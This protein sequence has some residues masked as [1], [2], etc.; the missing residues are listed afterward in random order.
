MRGEGSYPRVHSRTRLLLI[1]IAACAALSAATGPASA[2]ERGRAGNAAVYESAEVLVRFAPGVDA[3]ERAKTVGERFARVERSLPGGLAVVGLA[4]GDSVQQA[5]RELEREPGVVSAAPN[6]RRKLAARTPNDPR[7]PELWGLRKTSAA[8]AWEATTGSPSVAVAVVDTGVAGDHP[9]LSPNVWRNTAETV[10]GADDDGNGYVDDV[11]GWDFVDEDADPTDETGHGTHVAGTIGARG[12]DGVGVTGVNW[13]V[14]L[15]SLRAGSDIGLADDDI[16]E[17]FDYACRKGARVV[18]GSFSGGP[19]SF[20]QPLLDSILACPSALF[21]F[22]AGNEGLD[23]DVDPSYPCNFEAPNI[24]CVAA[25]DSNDELPGWSNHGESVDLAAPGTSILSS[26]AAHVVFSDS[27]DGPSLDGWETGGTG[28]WS[29]TTEASAS[30]PNS[31]TESPGGP[32]AENAAAWLRRTVPA[33]LRGYSR[34]GLEWVMQ[35]DLDWYDGVMIQVSRDQTWD[36]LDD[37]WIWTGSTGGAFEWWREDIGDFDGRARAFVGFEFISG[38]DFEPLDGVHLDDVAV[39]CYAGP[40]APTGYES[41]DGTSMATPHVAGAAALVLASWPGA[42]VAEL[43]RRLFEDVDVVP[44]LSG[45][46]ATGGRLN[47][48]KALGV[49]VPP[50]P[51]PAEPPPPPAE[52]PPPAPPGPPPP[53]AQP[54]PPRAPVQARCIVPNVKGKTVPA[55]RIALG[56]ARCALGRVT[57]AYS[58][59]VR[60]SRIIVQSRRVGSRH[61]RGTRVSVVVSRG[62]RR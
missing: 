3:L 7:W 25:S 2:V 28:V 17:A 1:A 59:R 55:A 24:L 51:P 39:R 50:P 33:D 23:N 13:S 29:Q 35:S 45:K 46:V 6:F 43:R 19:E 49:T 21:V 41:W 38:T 52:P 14:G 16:I 12:N 60:K 54:P 42:S 18:N 4:P 37:R 56:R 30:P 44:A 34:C 57:R 22:A 32:H 26:S 8:D 36:D 5:A 31:V 47:L 9:D 10:N 20:S 11:Q 48:A 62:R 40:G 58:A 61:P 15:M 27:F 53:P